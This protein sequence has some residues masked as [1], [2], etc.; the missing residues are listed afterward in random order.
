MNNLNFAN[1]IIRS[2]WNSKTS[3][4]FRK[5][6]NQVRGHDSIYSR[7][8][9]ERHVESTTKDS[10]EVMVPS[11][12]RTFLPSSVLDVGCGTGLM[13]VIFKQMGAERHLGLEYSEA[14]LDFCRSRGLLVRKFDLEGQNGIDD[15]KFDL[16]ISMEVA[17]HLPE[18]V[19]DS[20][21][22]LLC[23]NSDTVV[24]TAATP[25]QGGTDH[26]NEQPR[27][28]WIEK[29]R[30]AGFIEDSATC[31][32]LSNEWRQSGKVA[33]WYYQNLLVFRRVSAR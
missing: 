7:A 22:K 32:A 6:V 24:I 11:L 13:L 1:T 15:P 18:H 10:A 25:G 29:F 19:A 23:G 30:A 31:G 4:F 16:T 20:Y 21:V 12:V 5:V 3:R 28:Y 27:S 9:Y 33:T 17:E 14:G 8:Y 26:V 2:C